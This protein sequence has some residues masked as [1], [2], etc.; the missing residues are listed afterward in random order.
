LEQI[1]HNE[2]KI[3]AR[4]LLVATGFVI[5][6]WLIKWVEVLASV[7]LGEWGILPRSI[8]G[9]VGIFTA[10][11]IHG[12][13]WHLMS[14][15]F[16][17]VMLL[18]AIFYFYNR[19]AVEVFILI[20]L[21]TGFWVWVFAREAYHIGSSGIVYGLAT[22]L[23]FSGI[24]RRDA[25]SMAVALIIAFIHGGMLQG[26][27]PTHD[28]ISWESH[29]MGTTTGIVCSIY[30]RKAQPIPQGTEPGAVNEENVL[31]ANDG[32]AH[33]FEEGQWFTKSKIPYEYKVSEG[34]KE[35][36]YYYRLNV[37]TTALKI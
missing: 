30:F 36:V 32:W 3:F 2:G 18:I 4:S 5:L 12:S 25:R 19:I 37:G 22:F 33:T 29:V 13:P 24:L 34:K 1:I 20:Y 31:S 26:L 6:L 21:V 9:L 14:N 8:S 7:D 11:L 35:K 28:S 15:S 16:P 27:V 23:F 10:P 17:L